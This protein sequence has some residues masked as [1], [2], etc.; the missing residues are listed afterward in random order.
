[1]N[2]LMLRHDQKRSKKPKAFQVLKRK[3][4]PKIQRRSRF[5]GNRCFALAFPEL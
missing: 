2:I 4:V 5:Q 3:L 1:M